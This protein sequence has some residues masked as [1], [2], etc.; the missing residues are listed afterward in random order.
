VQVF[1]IKIFNLQANQDPRRM[2]R[3]IEF[4]RTLTKT[5]TTSNTFAEISRWY[6]LRNLCEFEW[7]IPSIWCE[8]N[9]Q[10]K[11]LLDHPSSGVRER[12]AE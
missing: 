4:M 10:A 12:I 11:A 2:Y 5:N 7:R 1:L 6:L 8:V 3:L 9:E